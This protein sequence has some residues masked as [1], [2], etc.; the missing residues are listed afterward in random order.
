MPATSSGTPKPGGDASSG[1]GTVGVRA[2]G[3]YSRLGSWLLPIVLL[4]GAL[5][6]LAG[7]ALR[8]PARVRATAVAAR[9]AARRAVRR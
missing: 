1:P 7:P 4:V 5:C 2:V 9:R 6:A 3:S 8:Y